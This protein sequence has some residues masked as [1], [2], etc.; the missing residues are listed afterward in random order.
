MDPENHPEPKLLI[1][2]QCYDLITN[3]TV[4]ELCEAL[5]YSKSAALYY[6]DDEFSGTPIRDV[7]INND[8]YIV[9]Y[10]TQK[11]IYD[12]NVYFESKGG[13]GKMVDGEYIFDDIKKQEYDYLETIPYMEI[14][15]NVNELVQVNMFQIGDKKI[16]YVM[17]LSDLTDF[18]E[19]IPTNISH[20][21]KLQDP[22][23]PNN[24]SSWKN[25]PSDGNI[26]PSYSIFD[27]ITDD[28]IKMAIYND[29][30]TL[31]NLGNNPHCGYGSYDMGTEY[32]EYLELPFKYPIENYG[33]ARVEDRASAAQFMFTVTEHN[34]DKI[35]NLIGNN[36]LNYNLPSKLLI[37]RNNIKSTNYQKYLKEI[38]MKYVL[39]IIPS[40]TILMLE[41][42]QYKSY[43]FTT[44][45][46]PSSPISINNFVMYEGD[47]LTPSYLLDT[48]IIVV[49]ELAM[50]KL[51]YTSGGIESVVTE[52]STQPCLIDITQSGLVPDLPD[53]Y[54]V[55]LYHFSNISV[56][57]DSVKIFIE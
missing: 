56:D 8:H 40:T 6:E 28:D 31:D 55:L 36:Q 20:F 45:T 9:P 11:Q 16:F 22:N 34:D 43:Y 21:F 4:G 19:T 25:I 46:Q 10:F 27:G 52:C 39:Q 26:D 17:D 14:V 12:G 30:I 13:W 35:D 54:K 51:R 41:N 44:N 18:I 57:N 1:E 24:F 15:Q 23:H 32:F 3:M 38:I 5:V 2:S 29:K 49:E 7:Y 53:G 48:T 50:A 47:K 42:K 33:F 37:I